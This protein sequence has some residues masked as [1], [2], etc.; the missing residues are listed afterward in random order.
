[1]SSPIIDG[2]LFAWKKNQDYASRLVADLND[3]QLVAQPAVD[4]EAPANHPAW[5]LSHLNAYV[6]IICSV[7]KGEEFEDPKIH[8]FGM[9]SKPAADASVYASKEEL[10]DAFVKGHEQVAEL[11]GNSDDSVFSTAVMLPRWREVMPTAGGALPY[12]MLNHENMHLGQ[13]SA[14][15]R[16]LGLPSV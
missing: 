13:V 9:H 2:L 7:I 3:E 5:V 15:R 14:W 11:L 8:R 10:V 4:P 16:V 6:P 1:M 12:L